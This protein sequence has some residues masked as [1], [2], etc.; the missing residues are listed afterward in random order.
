MD[1]SV[2][3][4]RVADFLKKHPPF[5][6]MDDGDL[7]TLAAR[8]RVRFHE[9]NDFIIWQGEPHKQYVFV[10]QQGT[11]SLWD[12]ADGHASLRDVRGAGD[13]LAIERFNQA[14]EARH[15]LHSARSESDVV[16]YAFPVADF[17]DLVLKYPYARQ[18]VEAYNTVAADYQWAKDARAPQSM[19]LNDVIGRG[20]R[21]GCGPDTTIRE[22]AQSMLA[23]GADAIAVVDGEQR[24]QGVVTGEALLAWV[25]AGAGS[26]DQP[27]A[28]LVRPSPPAVGSAATIT[29]AVL[30]IAEAGAD[31]LAVTAD[32]SSNGQAPP[33]RDAGGYRPG[34]RRSADRHP[35]RHSPGHDDRGAAR[36]QSPRPRVGPAIP[37]ER[38]FGRLARALSLARRQADRAAL[39]RAHGRRAWSRMLVLLRRV[40]TRRNPSPATL[41]SWS[42]SLTTTARRTCTTASRVCRM[43]WPN[44]TT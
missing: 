39:D 43:R 42:S 28:A 22:L 20:P 14:T 6:A 10:I 1:T 24:I 7:L 40:R 44:A 30:A 21:P 27:V 32:G 5:H 29:D 33:P 31:A 38:T 4:H 12:E 2:I 15:C 36:A 9:A 13:M 34:V 23:T 18:F 25:A 17:E 37:D 11:V 35:A 16:I 3:S 8:G 26:A 41:P 19:F